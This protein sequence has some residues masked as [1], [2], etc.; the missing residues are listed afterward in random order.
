MNN[1]NTKPTTSKN[2]D[3]SFNESLDKSHNDNLEKNDKHLPD[4]SIAHDNANNNF[5][6]N[7]TVDR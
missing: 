7:E 3:N 6:N 5:N 4:V 1:Y 2:F